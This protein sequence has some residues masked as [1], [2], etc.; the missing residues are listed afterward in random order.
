MIRTQTKCGLALKEH[1]FSLKAPGWQFT[2]ITNT[3]HAP[4]CMFAVSHYGCIWQLP[5]S[6]GKMNTCDLNA[7]V[8]SGDPVVVASLSSCL[9]K[10]GISAAV[11]RSGVRSGILGVKGDAKFNLEPICRGIRDYLGDVVGEWSVS[12]CGLCNG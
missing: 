2:C 11:C 6:R 7:V 3:S 8:I 1:M 4:H 5:N 10:F 9:E 12:R